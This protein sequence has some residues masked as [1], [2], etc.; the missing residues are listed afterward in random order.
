MG[1]GQALQGRQQ[2]VSDSVLE[3]GRD[4]KPAVPRVEDAGCGCCD[5]RE[6]RC[7]SWLCLCTE[8]RR[9]EGRAIFTPADASQM[10]GESFSWMSYSEEAAGTPKRRG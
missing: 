10:L 2:L 9:D 4:W 3:V 6:P 5:D 8:H 7:T 1:N